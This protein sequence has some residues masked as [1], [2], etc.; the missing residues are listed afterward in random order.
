MLDSFLPKKL[1]TMIISMYLH[2]LN[3]EWGMIEF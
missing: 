3:Q 2:L 1:K